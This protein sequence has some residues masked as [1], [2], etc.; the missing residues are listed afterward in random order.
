MHHSLM[1][2]HVSFV[3]RSSASNQ[4]I[5]SVAEVGAIATTATAADACNMSKLDGQDTVSMQPV[6]NLNSSAGESI[7]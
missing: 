5:I 3:R 4:Y 6:M 2:A 7:K 1:H